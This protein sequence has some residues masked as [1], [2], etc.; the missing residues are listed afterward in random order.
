MYTTNL[1]LVGMLKDT[2]NPLTNSFSL[3]KQRLDKLEHTYHITEWIHNINT[4]AYLEHS[5]KEDQP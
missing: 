1:G 3:F 5:Q 2:L 4:Y